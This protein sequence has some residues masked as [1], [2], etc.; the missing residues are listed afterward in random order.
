MDQQCS[1]IVKHWTMSNVQNGLTEIAGVD[2]DGAR[3]KTGMDIAGV[4]NARVIDSE[5]KL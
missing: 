4:D 1:T 5:F 2:I 3:K